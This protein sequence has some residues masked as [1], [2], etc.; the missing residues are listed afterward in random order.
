MA[1]GKKLLISLSVFAITAML[2]QFSMSHLFSK[3]VDKKGS[4]FFIYRLFPCKLCFSEY[5]LLSSQTL[6]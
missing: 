4:F 6:W 1:W 2:Q 5:F 3:G